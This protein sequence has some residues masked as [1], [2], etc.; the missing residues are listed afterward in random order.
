MMKLDLKIGFS[1]NNCCK[2]CA[3]GEKRV[4]NRDKTT[5]ELERILSLNK[6]HADSVVFTGGEPTI[7]KD[8]YELIKYAHSLGYESI[9]VQTNGRMFAYKEFCRKVVKAGANEFCIS[10][11][12]HNAKLHDYLTGSKGSFNQTVLGIKNLVSL[13]RNVAT[14]TVITKINYPYLA[15]IAK[16]LLGLRVSQYQF[17]FIHI[18]GTAALNADWIVPKKR[19]VIS[20]VKE[21]I[22]I[23]L[24][25]GRRVMTE[26]IPYCFMRGYENCV[27][28]DQI[29]NT[30]V[31]DADFT[32][33]NFTKYRR[34]IAKI[35][36]AVC[37][38]CRYGTVCEG[39]W[40]EYVWLFGW[41]EFNPIL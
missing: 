12:G 30:K 29:P 35:K 11:H 18:I 21:G 41:H 22:D 1:C 39:P 36:G 20:Y 3:Q 31:F 7:R 8:F 9:Q 40:R 28:E 19:E 33:N 27:A 10:L 38:K 34:K 2:F 14:N 24:R 32:V 5:L 4:I 37:R 13:G 26:A 6:K 15:G 25:A 17:A 16:F 23:G